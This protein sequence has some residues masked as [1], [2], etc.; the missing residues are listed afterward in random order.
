M[1]T[2]PPPVLAIDGPSGSGKGTISLKVAE[3]LGWHLLDSGALYRLVALAAERHGVALDAAEALAALAAG[4]DAVFGTDDAG[5]ERVLLEGEDVT[6]ELRAETSG[7]RASRVAAI[8]AVRAALV[9]RQRGFR[10]W[11]GLVADGRDMGSIIFP[12][13]QAKVFLTASPEERARRRYKQLIEKGIDANLDRLSAE[14]AERDR[15]DAAREVAPLRPAPDAR[16]IDT[17]GIGIPAVVEQVVAY[18]HQRIGESDGTHR[19]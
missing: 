1:T 8:P 10:Q 14:I 9:N 19:Q 2:Q 15:R 18:L 13:A 12:D 17:T 4:L 5:Q 11:P 7:D 6:R 16:L 3:R